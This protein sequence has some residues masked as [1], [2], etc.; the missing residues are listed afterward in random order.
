M[1][2]TMQ[3]RIFRVHVFCLQTYKLKYTKAKFYP[4]FY[5]TVKSGLS[6][7]RKKK[8]EG[9]CE[10]CAEENISILVEMEEG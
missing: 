1:L 2:A 9:V 6:L 7:S 8:T 5:T 3:F 4:F 10:E